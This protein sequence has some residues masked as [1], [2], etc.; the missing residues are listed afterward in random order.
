MPIVWHNISMVYV[1]LLRGIN[2]GGKSK[3]EMAKLKSTFEAL[4]CTDVSTYINS[5][6]VIFRDDRSTNELVAL[7]E[8][9]ILQDFDLPVPVVLRDSANIQK[10]CRAIPQQW[11]NDTEQRTDVMF[12]WNEIDNKDIL[13]KIVI[14]PEIENVRYVAGALVWNIGRQ[15]VTK[16]GGV[17]LIKT[18]LYKHLTIRN[19]NTVRKLHE[20][21]EKLEH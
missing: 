19:I 11:T 14:K 16:G 3:V 9:T 1:A 21:M 7:I 20:L 12:L 4:G 5:G 15:N 17:K 2:V 13:K 10:L 8:K 18:D 6:N